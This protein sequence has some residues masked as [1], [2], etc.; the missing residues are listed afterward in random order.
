MLEARA[1]SLA[2]R[3]IKTSS[4][5]RALDLAIRCVDLTTLEGADTPGKVRALSSKAVRPDPLDPGVPSVAAVCVYPT[6][7]ADAV[8]AVAGSGVHVASV[9]GAFPSGLSFL[10]LRL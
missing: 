4:K 1:A 5:A 6:L 3:S 8:A 9:A 10:D 7:V 2:S